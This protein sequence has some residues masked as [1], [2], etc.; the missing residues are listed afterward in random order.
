MKVKTKM[1]TK[2]L[3]MQRSTLAM[4]LLQQSHPMLQNRKKKMD[5]TASK[6][7]NQSYILFPANRLETPSK[8]KQVEM[9]LIKS[10]L[11][12]ILKFMTT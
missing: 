10:C 5:G 6:L 8:S 3:K 12:H 4:S 9:T 11:F 2:N 1:F 7:G